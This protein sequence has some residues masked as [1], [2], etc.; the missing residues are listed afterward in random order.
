MQHPWNSQTYAKEAAAA[1]VKPD[2]VAAVRIARD[3][4]KTVHSD[5]PVILSLGHLGHLVD[6]SGRTLRKAVD[7]TEDFYRVFQVKKRAAPGRPQPARAFRTI[8]VPHPPLMRT[9]RW[10]AQNVLNLIEPH[11]ASFA[12]APKRNLLGAA[13]RHA[14]CRWLLKMDVRNFFEAIPESSVF[15]VFEA[16]G[17]SRLVSFQLARICTRAIEPK[18]L[19]GSEPALPHPRLAEGHLPQGAPTSP[20]L[21]NLAVRAL[22]LKLEALSHSI[23]WLYT[24]Y[25]DDLAFST[26]LPSTRAQ[27][28]SFARRVATTLLSAG[29]TSN[30]QKTTIV[31]PGAR[32]VVLGLLVDRDEPRL[33]REFRNNLE[34]HLYALT[35]A[36][37]GPIKH[38]AERKFASSIGMARHIRGL[39][40]FAHMVDPAYAA[41]QYKRFNSVKWPGEE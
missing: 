14:G 16:L 41:G 17:Y 38:Q 23:G 2:V 34:T 28:A 40:A 11:S 5:L 33:T 1:G 26:K 39:L 21:A 19:S 10:I 12:F 30:E 13:E 3:R 15:E 8:C 31:P 37:I 29:L 35:S 36:A 9:Q 18:H 25:A 4:V 27:A 32:K 22:D 24:R 7:R 6:V 20:M